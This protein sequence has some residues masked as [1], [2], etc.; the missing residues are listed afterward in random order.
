[1]KLDDDY[2]KA[3]DESDQREDGEFEALPEGFYLC[4]VDSIKLSPTAGQSGYKQ[5]II[6]W[7]VKSPR[8]SAKRTIWDRRS[9]SPKAAWKMRELFDALGY[10]YGSDSDELVG[11]PAIVEID[12]Q[13]IGSGK[14]K[15]EMGENVVALYPADDKEYLALVGK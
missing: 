10:D 8:A 4:T 6:V 1:M 11:E 2:Q 12:H 5:W 3:M 15:G 7:K 13:P 14:R 9:L